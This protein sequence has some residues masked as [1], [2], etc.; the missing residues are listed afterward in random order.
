MDE[1]SIIFDL[2]SNTIIDE[3]GICSI[4]ICTIEYEK[5]NFTVVL[6]YM[7]DKIKL[8]SLV[9]FKLKNIS[10][11]NFL[12]EVIIRANPIGWINENKMLYWIENVWVKCTTLFNSQSLLILDSFSIH[13]VNF[14]KYRFNKKNTNIA[15]ILRELISYLQ[16]LN[17]LVNKSFKTV[18]LH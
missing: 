7:A 6:T 2:L 18:G 16:P 14:V 3:L 17:I 9:I 11:C 12:S 4:S 10:R 8:P 15:I 13:I 5:T 1:T